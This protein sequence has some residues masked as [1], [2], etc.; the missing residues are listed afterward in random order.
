MSVIN[1]SSAIIEVKKKYSHVIMNYLQS[2]NLSF[3][4]V[5][6]DDQPKTKFEIHNI[7]PSDA[8]RLGVFS[9]VQPSDGE[10]LI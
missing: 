1:N 8:F 2:K 9:Q 4:M 5:Q 7:T 3:K 10:F 6:N